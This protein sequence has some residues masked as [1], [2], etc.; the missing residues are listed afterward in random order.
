MSPA[1]DHH[2]SGYGRTMSRVFSAPMVGRFQRRGLRRALVVG[3]LVTLA[4]LIGA[5]LA[6]DLWWTMVP[7]AVAF[8]PLAG[9][10]NMSVRGVTEIPLSSLDER[11]AEQRMRAFHDAYYLGVILAVGGGFALAALMDRG[12]PVLGLAMALGGGLF[13]IPAMVLAWRLPDE[14][15]EM[16]EDAA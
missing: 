5:P 6:G 15:R 14:P 13:G 12:L 4:G 16:Q 10:I 7:F 3:M 9:C 2:E 1:R 11:M 8:F